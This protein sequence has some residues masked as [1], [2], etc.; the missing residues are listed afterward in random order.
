M[1]LSW[2]CSSDES[3]PIAVARPKATGKVDYATSKPKND[4]YKIA[5]ISPQQGPQTAQQYVQVAR[6]QQSFGSSKLILPPGWHFEPVPPASG[7]DG[8]SKREVLLVTGASGSGKSHWVRAYA[9]N[10]HKLFPDNAVYLISSLGKDETLDAL[11]FL[12][13]IDVDK[14]VASPPKDVHTWANSMVI[15]DDVEGLDKVKADAVQKV[16]DMIASEGRHSAT[17][18]IRA[19]HLSTDYK[20][21]RLLLQEAHGYVLFPQGGSHSQYVYLLTKYGGM[22]KKMA[23]SMLSIPA[24]WVYIHHTQPK[25][26]LTPD[27][28]T[29]LASH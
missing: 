7:E 13:R 17:T 9:N 15:I 27:Y 20:R 19:S 22:D 25:Y 6:P 18:L 28:I 23:A 4:P 24:R 12:K 2:D 5:F 26:V 29:L 8:K 10:Y 3:E 11:P 1:E 21:T 14:L 16:Q